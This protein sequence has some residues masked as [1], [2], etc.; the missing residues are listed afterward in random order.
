[1]DRHS[2]AVTGE[3]AFECNEQSKGGQGIGG[4]ITSYMMVG[5]DYADRTSRICYNLTH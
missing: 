4:S 5:V 2:G 3:N 1:M